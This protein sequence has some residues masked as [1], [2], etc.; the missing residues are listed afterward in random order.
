MRIAPDAQTD[1]G[2]LDVCVVGNISRLTAIREMPNLYRGT[3]VRNRAVSMH[4][5]RSLT[6]EGDAGTRVHLDGEPFGGLPL[7]VVLHPGALAVAV[8]G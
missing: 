5:A 4:I 7:E 2:H 6:V 8:P 1:D 3:H